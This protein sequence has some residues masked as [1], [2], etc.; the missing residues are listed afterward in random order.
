MQEKS[1]KPTL[2]RIDTKELE[3]PE[4]LYVRDIENRVFQGIVLQ[5]LSTIDGISLLEGNFIDSIFNRA[6][7][8]GIKGIHSEQDQKSHSVSI[9][10]E[11]NINY[12]IPIPQKAE[13]IQTKIA[14]QVTKLTGLHVSTIHVVIKNIVH[15]NLNKKS[16]HTSPYM[17]ES[18][19]EEEFRDEF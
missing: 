8:E 16:A 2:K 17:S 12:G 15:P 18:A 14:E 3:L 1:L 9:K 6:S 19:L 5:C 7:V 4:T 13:E 11:V 10:I